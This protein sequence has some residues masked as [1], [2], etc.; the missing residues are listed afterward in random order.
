[1][2]LG[3][4]DK[5]VA[6]MTATDLERFHAA[7]ETLREWPALYREFKWTGLWTLAI[8]TQYEQ[9]KRARA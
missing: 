1:M 3:E 4:W 6:A 8:T 7:L 5:D 9:E 2:T